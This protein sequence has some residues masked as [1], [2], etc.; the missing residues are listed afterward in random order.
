MGIIGPLFKFLL[1]EAG[2]LFKLFFKSSNLNG[3][4]LPGCFDLVMGANQ[5][6]EWSNWH[7]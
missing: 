6:L 7:C 4:R 2:Q 1:D 3:E 5:S